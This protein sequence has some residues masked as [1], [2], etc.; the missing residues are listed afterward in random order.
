MTIGDIPSNLALGL[1]T[2]PGVVPIL[3]GVIG[4]RDP[5]QSEIPKIV[6]RFERL[7]E[8]IIQTCPST[9]VWLLCGLAEGMDSIAAETFLMSTRSA[10]GRAKVFGRSSKF[11]RLIAVLPKNKEEYFNDFKTNESQEKLQQLLD[12]SCFIIEPDN[13]PELR[14]SL[15]KTLESP[16]CYVLQGDFIAKYS[17]ILFAFYDGT[18]TGLLG[19]TAHTLAI[20]QGVI[21]PLFRTTEEILMSRETGVAIPIETPRIS[22][23]STGIYKQQFQPNPRLGSDALKTLHYLESIN[24]HIDDS[25]FKPTQYDEVEGTFTK[26]WSY[27][28]RTAG[29]HKKRYEKIAI[30]LVVIGFLL[31]ATVDLYGNASAFGWG[32]I[33]ISFAT[34]PAVQ[35]K[36]QKPFLTYR[37]L[38]EGLTIQYIWST[39]GIRTSVADLLFDHDQ[40]DIARIRILLRTVALQISLDDVDHSK[41]SETALSKSRIWIKGQI[42]FLRRRIFTF[43]HLAMRWK[44][45]AYLFAGA[46]VVTASV[47]LMPYEPYLPE[48]LVNILLAGFASSLAYQELM[49]YEQTYERYETSL[50]QFERAFAALKLLEDASPHYWEESIDP[51]F[52]QKLVLDAIGKEKIEELNEWMVN[53]L[54]RTYQP[55]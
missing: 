18:D 55:A 46:G 10:R 24:K 28:D 13:N 3:I 52:R 2:D 9:P 37:C 45:I 39:N 53:Q 12:A 6:Q 44:R 36:L 48:Q 50:H 47:Q 21:H 49:G 42:D 51:R 29:I 23:S 11:D 32:L 15:D 17:Y 27:T 41:D 14:N 19:G 43:K 30:L 54:E 25:L 26:L 8:E 1:G 40:D 16:E 35:K 22:S 31:I 33:F 34:F 38:T 4:H 5:L 20:H 7:L